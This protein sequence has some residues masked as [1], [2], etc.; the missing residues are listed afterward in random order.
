[1]KRVYYKPLIEITIISTVQ[2]LCGASGIHQNSIQ[3]ASQTSGR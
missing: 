3:K 2:T 1:M